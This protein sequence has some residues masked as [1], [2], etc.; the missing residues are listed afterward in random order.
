MLGLPHRPV[1]FTPAVDALKHCPAGLRDSV[2]RM[3]RRAAVDGTAAAFA[4]LGHGIVAR[5]VRRHAGRAQCGHVL[6]AVVSFVLACRD[7]MP[8]LLAQRTQR[9]SEARRSAV[10][11]ASATMPA[12]AKPCRFSI[13]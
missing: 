10:P 6:S 3:P 7:A 12:T 1:L 9:S 4:G 2:A 11:L 5:Y 8:D 13:T